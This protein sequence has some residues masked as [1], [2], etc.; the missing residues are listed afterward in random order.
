MFVP[1]A[2]VAWQ[3]IIADESAIDDRSLHVGPQ[4]VDRHDAFEL[5]RGL[6]KLRR[7]FFEAREHVFQ[8]QAHQ[9]EDACA[10]RCIG[11]FAR[12]EQGE[13]DARS[14]VDERRVAHQPR[15]IALDGQ[16]LRQ[17][18]EIPARDPFFLEGMTDG[19][20]R[21]LRRFAKLFAQRF[22]IASC[23][24]LAAACIDDA[25]I[26]GKMRWQRHGVEDLWRQCVVKS[27]LQ[28]VAKRIFNRTVMRRCIR[29][30]IGDDFRHRNHATSP[31]LRQRLEIRGHLV[32]DHAGHEPR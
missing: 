30:K 7:R 29:Q 16:R 32:P 13:R 6:D 19:R 25:D 23:R 10:R 4:H 2:L 11:R 24:K 26:E 27:A 22:E 15:A 18:T 8:L 1:R 3:R 20:K 28:I 17:V 5:E 9:T 12:I 31:R 14:I 21:H